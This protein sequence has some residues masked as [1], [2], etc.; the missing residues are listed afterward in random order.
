MLRTWDLTKYTKLFKNFDS[1]V[2]LD[3]IKHDWKQCPDL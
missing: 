1:L 2:E 3:A